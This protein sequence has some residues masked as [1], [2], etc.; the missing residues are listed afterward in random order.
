MPAVMS[1]DK[2]LPG[3]AVLGKCVAPCVHG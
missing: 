2:M 3:V 1:R